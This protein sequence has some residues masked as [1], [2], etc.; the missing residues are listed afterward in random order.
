MFSL[1]R[2]Q[3]GLS[4]C[5]PHYEMLKSCSLKPI[6]VLNYNTVLILWHAPWLVAEGTNYTASLCCR[7]TWAGSLTEAYTFWNKVHGSNTIRQWSM[8]KQGFLRSC[9]RVVKAMDLKSI[10][11]SPR[12][13]ESCQ[14]RLRFGLWFQCWGSKSEDKPVWILPWNTMY[15]KCY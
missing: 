9:G 11:V 2:L 7:N 13:S 10:G 12:R 3:T 15:L 8:L 1:E 14:L 4:F 5:L 6:L